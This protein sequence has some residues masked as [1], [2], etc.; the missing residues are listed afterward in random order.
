MRPD[1]TLIGTVQDVAGTSVSVSLVSETATGLS[2]YQRRII[3][4]RPSRELCADSAG[5]Y[6]LVWDR[7]SGRGGRSTKDGG[8]HSS[9]GVI[10]G[11]KCNWLAKEVAKENSSEVSRSIPPSMMQ[12]TS[13]PKRTSGDLWTR[14]S[15]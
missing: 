12:S 14:R 11:S 8:R 9:R 1:P 13:S 4:N 7:L 2:F 10:S 6:V 3:Q 15:G 5:L